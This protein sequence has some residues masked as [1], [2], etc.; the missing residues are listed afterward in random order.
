MP[1]SV[2]THYFYRAKKKHMFRSLVL[3][4]IMGFSAQSIYAQAGITVNTGKLYFKFPPGSN[5]TQKLRVQNPNN[6]PLEVG[7]SINDWKYDSIGNNQIHDA[8]TLKNSCADWIKILPSSYF[9]LR[10]NETK[11]LDIV[12]TAPA[13]ADTSVPV[14]TAMLYLTQLNPGKSTAA[15]G[16]AI[17][18]TVRMGVKIYHSFAVDGERDM[19][20]TGFK[21]IKTKPAAIRTDALELKVKNTGKMWIDGNVKIELLNTQTGKKIKL[22]PFDF[23]SL[24]GDV[25]YLRPKLPANIPS[26]VYTATALVNYGDRDE[27]KVAEL[28]FAL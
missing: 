19:E 11:D 27:L 5:A 18:V 10:P 12:L 28:D 17:K 20:I 13:N 8:G 26:G 9:T 2:K 22:D 15:N 16:A 7:V 1:I 25:I 23:Y 4:I 14:H 21:D 6:T 24:P 3:L